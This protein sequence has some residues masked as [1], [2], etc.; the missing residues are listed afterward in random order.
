MVL[1]GARAR[2]QNAIIVGSRV[3]ADD[4]ATGDN[5]CLDLG[6]SQ[7]LALRAIIEVDG[8]IASCLEASTVVTVANFMTA[9]SPG[10]RV[11][12]TDTTPDHVFESRLVVG[13]IQFQ[14]LGLSGAP[15]VSPLA[16][17]DT[18]FVVLSNTNTL[19]ERALFSLFVFTNVSGPGTSVVNDA[20]ALVTTSEAAEAAGGG[21]RNY[22]GAIT[23]GAG[24]NPFFGWT[25]GIFVT[26]P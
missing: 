2:I 20:P 21:F 9:T 6:D 16:G 11:I 18:G 24:N 14:D 7:S 4:T 23:P 8:V 13:D 3:A 25:F 5:V 17:T 12:A 10:D 15:T 1:E 22:L 26:T 19:D